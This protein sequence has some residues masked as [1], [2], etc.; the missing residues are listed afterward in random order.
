[1]KKFSILLLALL[2]F[3][4]QEHS[5]QR[6][7]SDANDRSQKIQYVKDNRTELCFVYNVIENGHF[8]TYDVF[9]NVPCTPEVEALIGK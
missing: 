6:H 7:Y 3:S 2:C 4:C 8:V 1:M 5:K 9:T